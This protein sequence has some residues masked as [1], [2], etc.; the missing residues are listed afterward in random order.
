MQPTDRPI[1][2]ADPV[3]DSET[4][5]RLARRHVPAASAVLSVDETGGEARSYLL[6]DGTIFKTQRPHRV[7]ASTSI[8]KAVFF[9]RQ[10]EGVDGINVPRVLGYGREGTI[11]YV[12][13]T[14]VLGIA[15]RYA[16]LNE[17]SN[18][19][20]LGDLGRLLRR[21]HSVDQKP[22]VESHLLPQ[23]RDR[24]ALVQ[25]FQSGFER[26]LPALARDPGLWPLSA[27]PETVA[28]AA[29]DA[30]PADAPGRALHSNP[31]P[32][33]AFVDPASGVLTGLID[34]GD[35]FISHPA[36]ELRTWPRF[37]DRLDLLAGYRSESEVDDTFLGVWRAVMIMVEVMTLAAGPR[38][39][40]RAEAEHALSE[41]LGGG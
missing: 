30:L 25:R 21:I 33:H 11:E 10:L 14:R 41:L 26:A 27:A 24:Q 39:E 8:E 20:M 34:F 7:R 29:I 15:A 13:E 18:R 35:A 32:P 16:H 9:Q 23:D 2:P 3:L 4:V 31:G 17:E 38:P 6:D 5:L 40:R 37:Q 12:C 19:A 36:F 28:A 22:F 1:D